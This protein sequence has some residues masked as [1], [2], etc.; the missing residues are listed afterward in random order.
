MNR[1]LAAAVLASL[2][3]VAPGIAR[4][5]DI[6]RYKPEIFEDDAKLAK[7]AKDF[8]ELDEFEDVRKA[9][10]K[11]LAVTEFVVQWVTVAGQ[12]NLLTGETR[13]E[14][15][16]YGDEFK[17]RITED[18]YRILVAGLEAK[19][20]EILP[21]ERLTAT[22]EYATLAGFEDGRTKIAWGGPSHMK[23]GAFKVEVRSPEGMKEL[24][25]RG[26]AEE[27]NEENEARL[28][29]ALG[30]DG[31]IH[32]KVVLDVYKGKFPAVEYGTAISHRLGFETEKDK[33]TGEVH[34]GYRDWGDAEIEAGLYI[35]NDIRIDPKGKSTGL[36]AARFEADVKTI[37][38]TVVK[39][40]A[41]G[42]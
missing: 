41:T 9:K 35:E 1:I 24:P 26:D 19:G 38:T 11:R 20:F 6:E 40:A 4:A 36:D 16:F 12:A 13:S 32:A 25:T 3:L 28:I 7:A 42:M 5:T 27:A 2:C 33:K 8:F 15:V 18:L 10:P 22:P 34:Y 37:Y 29:E 21:K 30:L 23:R 17:N 39:M 31:V 14:N